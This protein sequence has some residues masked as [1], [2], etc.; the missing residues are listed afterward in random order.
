MLETCRLME[1][2]RV[3]EQGAGGTNLFSC[4]VSSRNIC[5]A[6]DRP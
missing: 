6:S 1:T 4:P 2:Y 3:P 5:A